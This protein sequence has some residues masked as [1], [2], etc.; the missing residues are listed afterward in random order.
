MQG[1]RP[2]QKQ[3]DLEQQLANE[4]AWQ[5]ERPHVR[6]LLEMLRRA[7][8]AGDLMDAQFA[9]IERLVARQAVIRDLQSEVESA[10]GERASAIG[11]EP[12][13]IERLRVAQ[14]AV[15]AAERALEVQGRLHRLLRSVGDV[16]FWRG[17]MADRALITA[18]GDGMEVGWLSEGAGW[19]AEMREAD[20]LWA[21]GALLVLVND[22]SQCVRTGDLT[23]VYEDHIQ[24]RE[25]KA[26]GAP[27]P[28]SVQMRRLGDAIQLLNDGAV[29]SGEERRAIV[30]GTAPYKTHLH[31][32]T[33]VLA[34][35]RK[36]GRCLEVVSNQHVVLGHDLTHETASSFPVPDIEEAR[37][38]AG[39]RSDDVIVNFGTTQRR[40]RDRH[41]N[42]PFLAPVGLIPIGLDDVTDLLVGILD[43]TTFLNLSAVQRYLAGRG[44]SV[45]VANVDDMGDKFLRC[46]RTVRRVQSR[47]DVA[48]GIRELMLIELMT[49]GGLADL[50]DAM[51]SA[52]DERSEVVHSKT[53][54]VPG[55][56]RAAWG[57]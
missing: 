45:Q 12:R 57:L 34:G 31:A 54:V 42:F 46:T 56:E 2:S 1:Y 37:S 25:V 38:L 3:R 19:E 10:K 55:D 21:E 52:L 8:T 24:I 53:A 23:C 29:E 40:M 30:R 28:D 15:R 33:G 6:R 32:L 50:I 26:S 51:F 5:A 43:Y 14:A 22:T 44:W 49:V 20:R 7:T 27:D 41:T 47:I 36:H 35:S 17:L 39:W 9:L 4:P 48:P 18:L 16:V 13:D 11:G